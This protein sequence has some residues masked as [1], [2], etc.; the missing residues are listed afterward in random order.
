[1]MK[2]WSLSWAVL[3]I[4]VLLWGLARRE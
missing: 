3:A 4:N 2:S 1:M